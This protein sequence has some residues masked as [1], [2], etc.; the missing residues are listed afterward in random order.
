MDR[1]RLGYTP[2]VQPRALFQCHAVAILLGAGVPAYAEVPRQVQLD[3]ERQDG[4][5]ACPDATTIRAGVAARLG[6]E[7]FAEQA[8]DHLRATIRQSGHTLEALIEMRD[9][10]G[11][12][13]A[14]RRLFSRQR[15]C[16]ELASSV[17]LAISIAIDPMG[18]PMVSPMVSLMVSPMVSPTGSPLAVISC[19]EE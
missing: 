2:A 1:G 15:D 10:Q 3:Y 6:Y 9:S 7:P 14:E 17:E 18:L 19:R 11:H 12:L 16:S 13:K 4:A 5:A 8:E